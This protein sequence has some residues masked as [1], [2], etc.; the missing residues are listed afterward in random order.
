MKSIRF[1][2]VAAAMLG[3][4]PAQAVYILDID[5]VGPDVVATGSGSIN[6]EAL[7]FNRS[8]QES[9]AIIP[10]AGLIKIGGS[11]STS[12]YDGASTLFSFGDGRST[13]TT[14]FTGPLVGVFGRI[15]RLY[16]PE[17]YES[18]SQLG[19][20]T[21]TFEGATLAGLGAT[22]GTYTW[23]WGE[24]TTADSFIVNIGLAPAAA[25]P[26]P[27]ALGLLGLG[28]LTIAARRRRSAKA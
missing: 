14:V 6:T 10:L 27:A 17:G 4:A 20:S 5:E 16:V 11:A 7:T 24:G 13:Y 25:V 12:A 21:A 23:T 2:L 3:A 22:P 18:G 1:S 26:A 9:S 28:A 15:G 8:G 19:V